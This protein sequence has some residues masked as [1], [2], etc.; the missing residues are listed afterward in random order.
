MASDWSKPQVVDRVTAVFPADIIGKLLPKWDEIP[1]EF[2]HQSGNKWVQF[3]TDWFFSG[4]KNSDGLVPKP[5]I[6][7]VLAMAHLS[8][9]QRSYQPKH[10]HKIAGVAYLASLWFEDTSTWERAPKEGA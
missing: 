4:L 10:E 8:A 2:K 1:E 7:K 6:D 3:Q 9:C 5:G